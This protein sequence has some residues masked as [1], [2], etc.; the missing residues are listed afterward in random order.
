MSRL[1]EILRRHPALLLDL[2]LGLA[3]LVFA[4]AVATAQRGAQIE[5]GR[6]HLLRLDDTTRQL[7]DGLDDR[8]FLTY[9]VSPRDEMP[10]HMRRLER[11]VTRFLAALSEAADGRVDYQIVDPTSDPDLEVFA[12]KRKVAPWRARH[13]ARDS[14]SEQEVWS[15]LTI[16]YGPRAPAMIHG[17][18]PEHVPRLQ[19]LVVEHL[20]AMIDP[21]RPVIALAAPPGFTYLALKLSENADLL[22]IDL[23]G[24]EP[25]PDEAD[26]LFWIEPRE[27]SPQRLRELQRYL[28]AGKSVVVAGAPLDLGL[29]EDASEPT[30]EFI[31]TGFDAAGFWDAFGLRPV[32]G[33]VLDGRNAP[34]ILSETEQVPAPFRITCIATNHD[35]HTMA[36]EPNGTFL[37]LA[38]TPLAVDGAR[39]AEL[40][41]SATVLASTSEQ[42]W[43]QD[44]PDGPIAVA[45]LARENGLPATK[46]P[47]IV[48]LTRNEPWSGQLIAM[49]GSTPFR[50]EL[51]MASGVAHQRLLATLVDT[52]T[53]E[54]RLVMGRADVQAAEP[55]PELPAGER[56]Q[57][58]LVCILAAPLFMA[59]VGLARDLGAARRRLGAALAASL[60]AGRYVLPLVLGVALVGWLVGHTPGHVD[61]TAEGLNSVHPTTARY[62]RELS[63]D[64]PLQVELLFSAPEKLPP[65]LRPWPGRVADLFAELERSG[66]DVRLTR[67]WPDELDA[68]ARGAL[69]DEDIVPVSVTSTDEE[70]TTV[71]R[72]YLALRLSA[73]ERSE[74]LRFSGAESFEALEFRVAFALHRLLTGERPHIVFASDVPRLSAAE[75][76]QFFQTQG[77]ISPQGKDVYSIARDLLEELDF[78]VS[79]VNPQLP[80]M[81]A[82]E[83]DAILWLQPRRPATPFLAEVVDA[84][85]RGG[86]VIIAA[87]HF[88]VQS[89]QYRGT[90]FEFVYWP[91][92]QSPDLELYWLP[93]FGVELVRE[94]L[95]DRV[96]TRVSLESQVNRTMRREFDVMESVL[97]FNIRAVSSAFDPDSPITKGL[98]DQAF[99]WASFLRWDEQRLAEVGLR[100][101]PLM[102]TSPESWH[103]LWSGGWIPPEILAGPGAD[104]DAVADA[105]PTGTAQDVPAPEYAGRLPLAALFEGRFPWPRHEFMRM[106]VKVG[107][108]GQPMESEAPPEYA[109]PEPV[110]EHADGRLL[111]IGCSEPFK[112]A[113]LTD[114]L[115]A[116]FRGDQLLVNAVTAMALPE[117]LAA[118][119]SRRPV[120]RGFGVVSDDVR[121]GWRLRVLL[122]GPAAL[123]VFAL[124]RRLLRRSTPVFTPA[125]GVAA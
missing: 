65:A 122:L 97:P 80:E 95:F 102:F 98:G 21:P 85:Y 75:A 25:L 5:L 76:H 52:L 103:F 78:R 107:P 26:V 42:T 67:T 35:F 50:D 123:L 58:R 37:F 118:V 73:G 86:D 23:G 32:E 112:D 6:A 3:V 70:V 44:V 36:F 53:D 34:L 54:D 99:L 11:D 116:E 104:E 106:P 114:P 24:D 10:S 22:E 64:G 20:Q 13:V 30:V 124:L 55:L 28:A 94:P 56:V 14:Y 17:V 89:R 2:G 110:D 33:L 119:A 60:R 101:T 66:A 100:A 90:Q 41:W 43:I 46:Q 15:T 77:L 91:Q 62:A 113:R 16:A 39:L 48:Q 12:G 45:Q 88:N 68:D 72:V 69:A 71:R 47:L 49:A 125:R 19:Q 82:D 81:P 92:P 61:L 109:L 121:E 18:S 120:A 59:L 79:H 108:D 74:V 4:V 27:V 111:L 31:A 8:V 87:Q 7:L 51:L 1:R 117:D 29:L 83:V 9:Y 40:G 63:A 105:G 38:P 84:L 115:L 96:A 93:E 57:W